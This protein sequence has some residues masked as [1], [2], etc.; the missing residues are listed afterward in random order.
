[1]NHVLFMSADMRKVANRANWFTDVSVLYLVNQLYLITKKWT[2]EFP[3]F[4]FVDILQLFSCLHV[5]ACVSSANSVVCT[6]TV[7]CW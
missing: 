6:Q 5:C 4:W 1:M 7:E 3:N 2:F